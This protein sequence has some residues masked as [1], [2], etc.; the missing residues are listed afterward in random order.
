M[1]Y[2]YL[3]PLFLIG[4]CCLLHFDVMMPFDC[5]ARSNFMVS[6]FSLIWLGSVIRL[7]TTGLISG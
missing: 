1:A 7:Y 2:L 3:Q 4:S 6:V 5:V